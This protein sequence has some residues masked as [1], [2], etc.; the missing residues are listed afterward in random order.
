MGHHGR[1]SKQGVRAVALR[2]FCNLEFSILSL[3]R[4]SVHHTSGPD[5]HLHHQRTEALTDI[6]TGVQCEKQ[7][8]R[9]RPGHHQSTCDQCPPIESLYTATEAVTLASKA[10]RRAAASGL[11]RV[12]SL[13][14]CL[15][16]PRAPPAL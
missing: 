15:A 2:T 1:K 8:P 10:K 3:V 6:G 5:H 16:H 7:P 14:L 9:L 11:P 12:Q 13:L 4:I